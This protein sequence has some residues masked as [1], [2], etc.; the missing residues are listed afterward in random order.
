[1][2]TDKLLEDLLATLNTSQLARRAFRD[3]ARVAGLISSGYPGDGVT[4]RHLQASSELFFDVFNDFDPDNRLLDQARR[5]VLENQLEL[6]RLRGAL[7]TLAT[8]RL[9]LVKT[10]R[11]SPL[12]FPLWAERLREQHLSSQSWQEQVSKMALKLDRA[13]DPSS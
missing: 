7:Q 13:A 9:N 2:K 3:I 11:F 6:S 10:Q 5:E 4:S 8:K 1:M 12:A